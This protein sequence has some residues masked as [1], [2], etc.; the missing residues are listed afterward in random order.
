MNPTTQRIVISKKYM[1]TPFL[2]Y[3]ANGFVG[4]EVARLAVQIGLQPIIAGRNKE[5]LKILS[6]ELG[7]E[8]RVFSLD[9]AE[10]IER[11]IKDMEVV[12]HCAGPYIYTSKPMVDACLK[13]RTH[14]L[15]I[16]GEIPVYEDILSRDAEAKSKGVMLLPGVGF[17]IVPTDCLAMHLKQRLPSATHLSLAFHSVGPAGLPP[18]T[19]KTMFELIPFGNRVRIEG[20]LKDPGKE[21]KTRMI[22]FGEGPVEATRFTWGD[23][24]TAWFSTGIPNIEDYIVLSQSMKKGLAFIGVIGPLFKM[25]AVRNF[26]KLGVKPGPTPDECK[27]TVTHVWG[28]V[29][30]NSGNKAEVRLYGPEAGLTWTSQTALAAVKKI[31]SGNISPGYQTPAMAFGA[32][33][34]L[35]LEGVTREDIE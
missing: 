11:E 10:V 13:T 17:D 14:Y 23:V 33:F 16:T 22:D 25:A 31:L 1:S 29:T 2:I 21:V 7:L 4:S 6:G 5:K 9:D 24:F 26:F 34:V 30:D 19:Q 35:E 20:Q 15:D 32:D 18:G 3:G 28:E 12:L 27:K 8:Y